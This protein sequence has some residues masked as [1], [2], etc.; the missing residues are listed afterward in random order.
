VYAW[1]LGTSGQLGNAATSTSN[2]PVLATG[3]SNITKVAAGGTHSVAIDADGNVWGFGDAREGRIG[4]GYTDTTASNIST[5]VKVWSASTTRR[6]IQIKASNVG[7][8]ILTDETG[9]S[10]VYATG[11][12][13]IWRNW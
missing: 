3:L 1:G 8:Y 10:Y 6:A 9:S 7:T 12:R 11:L 4:N 2:T 13:N 5:P